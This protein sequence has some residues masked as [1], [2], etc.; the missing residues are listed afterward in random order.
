MPSG[1][2][3]RRGKATRMRE[4]KRGFGTAVPKTTIERPGKLRGAVMRWPVA[5][6]DCYLCVR[7]TGQAGYIPPAAHKQAGRPSA[8]RRPIP[9]IK[10]E[11]T[12]RQASRGT[13]M[14]PGGLRCNYK[15]TGMRR[16]HIDQGTEKS[17]P[18]YDPNL[19]FP[20]QK[21]HPLRPIKWVAESSGRW[22]PPATAFHVK[23]RQ[24]PHYSIPCRP[25]CFVL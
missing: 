7:A 21:T 22:S 12:H 8:D 25:L 20:Q 17:S 6:W 16:W 4:A 13:R 19:T 10:Q 5:R 1:H 23:H 14:C 24:T 2:L 3:P 18:S 11:E 9:S 15:Q